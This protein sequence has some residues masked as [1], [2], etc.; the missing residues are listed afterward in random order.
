MSFSRT[1]KE[2]WHVKTPKKVRNDLNL[3]GQSRLQTRLWL[4]SY[5]NPFHEIPHFSH[6]QTH[7]RGEPEEYKHRKNIR[8]VPL[9]TG[10]KFNH[11]SKHPGK[12][13]R[14]KKERRKK[15][16]L[17]PRKSTLNGLSDPLNN[18]IFIKQI[19]FKQLFHVIMNERQTCAVA[20]LGLKTFLQKGVSRTRVYS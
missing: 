8:P 13:F 11:L 4:R 14:K 1:S 17:N 2:T 10:E 12:R 6:C 5:R 15:V 16:P 20:L 7:S 9:N 3:L 18:F 19:S